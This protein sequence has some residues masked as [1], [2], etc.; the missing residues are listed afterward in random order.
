MWGQSQ[1]WEM[2]DSYAR[3]GN[4]PL[5][6]LAD[7]DDGDVAVRAVVDGQCVFQATSPFPG[8]GWRSPSLSRC[9]KPSP[10]T[11]RA[12]AIECAR[13]GGAYRLDD[14]VGPGAASKS[15]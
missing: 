9:R 2:K 15:P 11:A 13:G 12:K 14:D 4:T 1:T 5:R 6:S 8:Q 7:D 3:S 10:T